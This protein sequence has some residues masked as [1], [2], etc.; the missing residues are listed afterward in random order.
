MS[1]LDTDIFGNFWR[2][3][4]WKTSVTTEGA[5]IKSKCLLL[6]QRGNNFFNPSFSAAGF[7]KTIYDIV[8]SMISKKL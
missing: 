5:L 1:F 2:C 4:K 8:I 6:Q 3:R 7:K